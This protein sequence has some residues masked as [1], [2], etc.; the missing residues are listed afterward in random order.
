MTGEGFLLAEYDRQRYEY[1]KTWVKAGIGTPDQ[2]AR[3]RA[4]IADFEANQAAVN[5]PRSIFDHQADT[6]T[7]MIFDTV[8]G[9]TNVT[10]AKNLAGAAVDDLPRFPQTVK[11]WSLVGL[12]AIQSN[13]G[14]AWRVWVLCHAIDQAG[15]GRAR[16]SDLWRWLAELGVGDRKRRRW[17]RDA[18]TI[19]LVREAGEYYYL[20]GLAR[21]AIIL[22]CDHIGRPAVISPVDLMRSGWRAVVWSAYLLTLD[23]RPISQEK[24]AILTGIDPRTQRNYQRSSPGEVRRNYAKTDIPGDHVD[25]LRDHGKPSAFVGRDGRIVY[26]LPDIRL[27]SGVAKLTSKGR[28]RKAQRVINSRVIVARDQGSLVRLFHESTKGVKAALRQLSQA[29]IPP[30]ER[31]AELFSLLFAGRSVN[32]W[33]PV[34]VGGVVP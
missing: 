7:Q 9:V 27:V 26:R 12:A 25:G 5:S 30:W 11:V 8:S 17:L 31:P 28:S 15:S 29:D 18:I 32:L 19:G 24:K 6:R 20:A 4:Y 33:Q 22:G 13:H 3:Y 1:C 16:R 21:A 10:P 2:L 34:A 14:G 23:G